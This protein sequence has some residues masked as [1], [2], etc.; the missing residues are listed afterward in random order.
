[1]YPFPSKHS[2]IDLGLPNIHSMRDIL[3]LKPMKFTQLSL[4]Q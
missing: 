3:Q 4:L 2:A 1:M